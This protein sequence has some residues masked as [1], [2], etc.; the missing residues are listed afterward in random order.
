MKTYAIFPDDTF[1][2]NM[3]IH[4]ME[5]PSE[6]LTRLGV[7][8]CTQGKFF[9]EYY[10][11]IEEDDEVIMW[12]G[13]RNETWLD[14]MSVLKCRKFLRNIDSCKSDRILFKREQEIFHRVGFEAMLVTYCTDYNKK[15]LA[16]KNIRSIDYPHFVDFNNSYNVLSKDKNYDILVSGHMSTHSYPLRTKLAHLLLEKKKHRIVHLPHP[17]YSKQGATH[18]F[19]G[20]S[21]IKIAAECRLAIL[22]TGDDDSLV[23]KYLE[24]AKAGTLPVGDFPSNMPQT[25]REAMLAV[26][27]TDSDDDILR[28]IDA[29]LDDHVSLDKKT[30]SYRDGM[31]IFD[32]EEGTKAV[33]DKIRNKK[34]DGE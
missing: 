18:Q 31:K 19:Y 28:R 21:Y 2:K 13:T 16:E 12:I 26:K 9:S 11:S 1:M 17:G 33:L 23:M 22:C 34:Y 3:S 7:T 32:I 4:T 29:L 24:F 14:M 5:K 15:F 10:A 25:S 27:K 20:E 30:S 6:E 8:C